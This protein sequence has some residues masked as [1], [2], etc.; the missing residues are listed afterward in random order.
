MNVQ[1]LLYERS[2]IRKYEIRGRGTDNNKV[3]F[4][5]LDRRRCHR[6]FGRFYAQAGRCFVFGCNVTPLDTRASA[7]PFITGFNDFLEI[8]ICQNTFRQVASG[9]SDFRIDHAAS[10]CSKFPICC[11]T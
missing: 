8:R 2:N 4:I 6:V 9:A 5:G 3:N 11:G 7:N 1:G 10:C